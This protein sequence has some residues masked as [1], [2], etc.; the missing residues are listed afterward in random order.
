MLFGRGTGQI[1]PLEAV[2]LAEAAAI[3]SGATGSQRTVVDRL[4][5]SFGLDVLRLEGGESDTDVSA[6][7]G[8]YL[9]PG[10][11][12]GLTGGS[13]PGTSGVT[14]E[15]EVSPE[16]VVEGQVGETTKVGVRWQWD[17]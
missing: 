5:Q 1:S 14:V 17:Y 16:I 4:R 2:Q 10:L 3:L 8:Q 9:A 15:Y 6:T 12:L 11:F 13:T 7:L